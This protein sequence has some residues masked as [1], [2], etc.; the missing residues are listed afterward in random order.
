MK[1]VLT[2]DRFSDSGWIYERKLD[3]IRCIAV[4]DGGQ[5]RL[6]SRNDIAMNARYPEVA[7]ALDAQSGR[8]A[9]DGEIVAFDG[10]ETSFAKLTR[11]GIESV[12]VFFYVFDVL[13]LDG[14]D[15]RPLPLR[16][17][18]RLLRAVLRFDDPLRATAHRNEDGEAFYEEACRKGWEGIIAKRADSPYA[19]R[20]SRDWLKFKCGHGQE[21][22]IGGFTEPRGTRIELGALLLGYYDA[23]GALRYA[24][25][26]GTGFDRPALRDLGARLR[27]LRRDSSPFAD[28][29]RE[30]G[31]TWTEPRL[32]AQIGF[33]EWTRDGRLRHPRYLG[34]REDKDASEVVRER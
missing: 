1:A 33:A 21:L 32:V 5:V 28:E 24:G 27:E 2:D 15:V 25:K 4:R 19:A 10:D 9:V 3:G 7:A 6:L 22:V 26:V 14:E 11:R 34:L 17:R 16:A 8:F 18:K 12:P 31:V 29:I 13:W 20:R 30:R 23:E